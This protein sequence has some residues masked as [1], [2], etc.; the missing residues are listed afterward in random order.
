MV[1]PVKYEVEVEHLSKIIGK[2]CLLFW[3]DGKSEKEIRFKQ[4]ILIFVLLTF[5]I[6][7]F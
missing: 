1:H 3:V 5:Q 7:K 4:Q 6:S 2:A